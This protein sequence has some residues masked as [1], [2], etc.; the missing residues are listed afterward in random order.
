MPLVSV[1]MSSY[2]HEKFIATAIESVLG[3][4]FD[5]LELIIVDDASS[6]SSREIIQKYT[7]E[8]ARV[9]T[10][11]HEANRGI[12][13]TTNDGF[14]AAKGK[15]L[16]GIASDDVWMRDKLSK[17]LAVLESNDD[18]IVWA[19]GEVIDDG[20]KAVGSTWNEGVTHSAT[21][22]K[23]VDIFQELLPCSHI[24]GS[25]LIFK[26]ANLGGVRLDESF[27]YCND[28]KFLLELAAKYKF[29]YIQEPLAQ[30]RIHA[31]NTWGASGPKGEA[32][33]T[34]DLEEIRVIEYALSQWHY[35]ISAEAK[36]AALDTLSICYSKL[37]QNRKA[38]MLLCQAFAYDPF[39]RLNL[40][41][42]GIFYQFTLN[43]LGLGI[44]KN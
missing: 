28:W 15:F 10:I 31:N 5:D 39:R 13:K 41:Y 21:W 38:L 11:L 44:P 29:Y 20:G 3:Q 40:K 34:G 12:A 22:K 18:L 43:V 7:A 36:A 1:V 4:D 24:F 25:T 14:A 23:S 6:D 30:Y 9:R 19:E 32:K 2:N 33:R 35:R 8:D 26:R 37:G 27:I 42:L 16:A 17:Q